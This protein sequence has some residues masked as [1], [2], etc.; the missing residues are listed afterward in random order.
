MLAANRWIETLNVR[1]LE[2]DLGDTHGVYLNDHHAIL[3]DKKLAPM[4][5][6][7]TLMHELGHAY[8]RHS[9][10]TPRSER[11]ASDWAA[12]A[13]IRICEFLA[14]SKL[15]DTPQAVAWEMGVL[16]RDVVNCQHWIG[17]RLVGVESG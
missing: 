13:M 6:Y 12:R 1:V 10:S 7:S 2:S 15:H 11:E 14:L 17:G 4:Q 3:I 9:E 8:Y 16:P 5:R